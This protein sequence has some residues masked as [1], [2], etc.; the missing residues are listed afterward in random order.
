MRE[1]EYY[2]FLVADTV[3]S[4]WGIVGQLVGDRDISDYCLIW[5]ICDNSNWDPKRFKVNN[6]WFSKKEFFSFVE[7]EWLGLKVEGRGDF[8]L[9]EKLRRLKE[10][11]R[12]WNVNIWKV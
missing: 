6:E 12:W 7:K 11:L 3:V 8:V 9:K 1:V 4:R 10:S 5:L 2:R